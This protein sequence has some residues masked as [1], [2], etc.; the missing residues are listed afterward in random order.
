MYTI[1]LI[2]H[3]TGHQRYWCTGGRMRVISRGK[4]IR[5]AAHLL[6]LMP[7]SNTHMVEVVPLERALVEME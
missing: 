2:H 7:T 4:A 1:K 3:D 6:S 5:V